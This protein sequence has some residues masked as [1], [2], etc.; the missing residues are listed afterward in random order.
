MFSII[1]AISA[2]V[3][4]DED[5]FPVSRLT[6]E[7]DFVADPGTPLT[8]DAQLMI[9]FQAVFQK[10]LE[11]DQQQRD[12]RLQELHDLGDGE[13][14]DDRTG[15]AS[16]SQTVTPSKSAVGSSSAA[17]TPATPSSSV[18]TPSSV[19][20]SASSSRLPK[21]AA[22]LSI[23]T[24]PSPPPITAEDEEERKQKL[25]DKEKRREKRVSKKEEREKVKLD[26]LKREMEEDVSEMVLK[27]HNGTGWA[28]GGESSS[29]SSSGNQSGQSGGTGG[30]NDAEEEGEVGA[31]RR[32]SVLGKLFRVLSKRVK[33]T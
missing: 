18:S 10:R 31:H 16:D 7:S 32:N 5:G 14:D 1:S 22:R 26:Q 25:K 11:G 24:S 8:P 21:L 2:A 29:S 3:D 27:D 17:S 30:S 9:R 20:S 12:R 6:Q 13:E 15:A 19:S 33:A 4:D 23:N 28:D